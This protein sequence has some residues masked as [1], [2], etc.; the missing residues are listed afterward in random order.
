MSDYGLGWLAVLVL[1][2]P[3]AGCGGGGPEVLRV[4]GVVEAAADVNPDGAGQA[5]PVVVR[6]YQL[7][8]VGQFEGAD[9]FSIYDDE[10][11]TLGQ[12]LIAREELRLRPGE[13]TEFNSE[14]PPDAKFLGVIAAFRD[15]DTAHWRAVAP[16]PE[17][18]LVD[19]RVDLKNTEITLSA[20]PAP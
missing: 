8:N 10:A 20:T 18:G 19:V 9:F 6:L 15:L 11:A 16:L 12:D 3:L 13:R 1:V 4:E 14:L 5:A 17:S 7:R 2:L